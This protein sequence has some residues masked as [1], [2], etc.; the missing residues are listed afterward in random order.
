MLFD[1]RKTVLKLN[2]IRYLALL[3][4]IT[5]ICV[6][7]WSGWFDKPV[8]R[9]NKLTYIIFFTI[10]YILFIL[11]FY[12][13]NY[14][15]FSFNDEGN[16]LIFRFVSFRPF[17]NEKKAIEIDKKKFGGYQ[18]KRSY[19][20]LKLE[21]ILKVSTKQG[22]ANYPPISISALSDK[23]ITLLKNALSHYITN[24]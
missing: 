11:K 15:Y 18:F 23:D 8:L 14:N 3:G 7:I 16:K 13:T 9:I 24:E 1:N 2:K 10:I 5:I 21:L 20:N 12:V 17:D 4:Y 22:L 6:I 19:L